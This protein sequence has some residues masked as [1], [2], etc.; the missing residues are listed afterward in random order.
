MKLSNWIIIEDYCA[1][2]VLDGT[3][4]SKIENRVAFIEKTPRIR[5]A[6]F[7]E[8]DDYKNWKYGSKGSEYGMDEESRKWCDDE[9]IKLGYIL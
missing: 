7:T 6:P 9:L 8:I 5:V 2:R 3:D 1:T 4:S